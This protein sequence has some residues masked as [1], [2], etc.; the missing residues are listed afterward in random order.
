[1]FN[2]ATSNTCSHLRRIIDRPRNGLRG[3]RGGH[4]RSRHTGTLG[5]A[6]RSL[7][8]KTGLWPPPLQQPSLSA[9]LRRLLLQ[10]LDGLSHLHA[11][12]ILHCKLRPA[13]V[14][15]NSHGTLKLSG[16]GLGRKDS[17]G[18]GAGQYLRNDSR[19]AVR[20]AM[21]ADGFDPP[22][23]MRAVVGGDT[24][25]DAL[26]MAA[27][28]AADIFSAGVLIFWCLT[29]GQHPFGEDQGQRRTNVLRGEPPALGQLRKLPEAQHLVTRMLHAEAESRLQAEQARK[30]PALWDDTEKL[31][32]V[33]CVSD[34][35]ELTDESSTFVLALEDQSQSL[36]GPDGWGGRIHAELL[37]V[38]TAHRSYQHGC[39]RDL[40]R[41][42]RNCD[43]L[44][45]MPPEVQKLLLPR[46]AGIANYFL[47]RFPAL[48]WALYSLAEQHW[49]SRR[50]FEPFFQWAAADH[51]SRPR[52]SGFL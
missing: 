45:G 13:S 5:G 44:Q 33:R 48:F 18:A 32:F 6:R 22:E 20:D 8:V 14:L 27:K 51:G 1:M 11:L 2:F 49:R 39:V 40:L 35:P 46:P 38:L 23:I 29:A 7:L 16:L 12:G 34:E 19:Q 28:K 21:A 9:P 3:G 4:R 52:S 24:E 30:H 41:A 47:P 31:L 15:L 26:S 10:L 37:A 25:V 36:F 50:V 42:V 43:H 17:P